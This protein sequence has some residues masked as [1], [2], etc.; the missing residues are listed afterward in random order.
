MCA[1]AAHAF[2]THDDVTDTGFEQLLL[3]IRDRRDFLM[4]AGIAILADDANIE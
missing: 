1:K 2:N 3:F 4:N